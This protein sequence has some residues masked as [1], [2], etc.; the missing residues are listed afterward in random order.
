MPKLPSPVEED[1]SAGTLEAI[2]LD[3]YRANAKAQMSIVLEDLDAEIES[4]PTSGVGVKREVELDLLS[5]GTIYAIQ[6]QSE[7]QKMAYR[8]GV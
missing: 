6:R 7:L 5:N 3:S 8:H 2:D 4:V 1:L